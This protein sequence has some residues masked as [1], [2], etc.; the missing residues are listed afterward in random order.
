MGTPQP[1]E[2][3]PKIL[4]A[5]AFCFAVGIQVQALVC[6]KCEGTTG[7]GGCGTPGGS[8][9]QT[10][11]NTVK[12]CEI[13]YVNSRPVTKGCANASKYSLFRNIIL[14]LIYLYSHH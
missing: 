4:F 2:M 5:F 13:K 11:N 9:N 7:A 1:D 8:K 12:F 10:C 14:L 6:H 3:F